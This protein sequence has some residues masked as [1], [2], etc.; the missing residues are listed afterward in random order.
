MAN[1]S[2][3]YMDRPSAEAK[4]EELQT[5][6]DVRQWN[7]TFRVKNIELIKNKMQR[8]YK[9]PVKFYPVQHC[10]EYQVMPNLQ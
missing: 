6:G 10:S 4:R 2:K 9:F 1:V 5:V 3:M 7:S 8:M